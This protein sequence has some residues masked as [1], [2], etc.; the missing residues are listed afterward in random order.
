MTST[1][2]SRWAATWSRVTLT[3]TVSQVSLHSI[4]WCL[5]GDVNINPSLWSP[6]LSLHLW[7]YLPIIC[8]CHQCTCFHTVSVCGFQTWS[9]DIHKYGLSAGSAVVDWM[10]FMQLALTRVEAMTLASALLEEGFLRTVGLKSAEALR[11][12]SLSEQ[13]MDD[14]TALYSFVSMKK[15]WCSDI[16]PLKGGLKW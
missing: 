7:F 16:Q 15:P 10:V 12:A 6:I 11:T 8:L 13:F 3:A 9:L 2:A 1:V 5:L 4:S 14:S